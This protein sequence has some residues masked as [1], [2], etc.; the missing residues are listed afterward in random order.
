MADG[1]MVQLATGSGKATLPVRLD[2]RVAAGSVWIE[3]GYGATAP[4]LTAGKLEVVRA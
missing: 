4:L 3:S 1:A 2:V